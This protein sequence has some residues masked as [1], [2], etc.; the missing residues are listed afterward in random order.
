MYESSVRIAKLKDQVEFT[1]TIFGSDVG[2]VPYPLPPPHPPLA[3]RART[4][5]SVLCTHVGFENLSLQPWL[6]IIHR[7]FIKINVFKKQLS[8]K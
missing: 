3:Y 2:T 1:N 4:K 8:L 6:K 7:L 5:R